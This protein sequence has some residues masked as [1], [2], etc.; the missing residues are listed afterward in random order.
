MQNCY[1][2]FKLSLWHEY[3]KKI[4]NK[5]EFIFVS[6]CLHNEFQKYVRLSDGDLKG[7]V[8]IINNSVGKVFE[9]NSYKCEGDKNMIL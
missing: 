8:H 9:D 2:Q 6:N 4:A 3:Y 1:D 7:H 5:A